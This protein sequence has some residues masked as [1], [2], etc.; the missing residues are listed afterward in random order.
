MSATVRRVQALLAGAATLLAV[1]PSV[2]R[3]E[4][5]HV[6]VV[7]SL[8]AELGCPVDWDAGCAA[9]RLGRIGPSTFAGRFTVPAG[10]FEYAIATGADWE[11]TAGAAGQPRPLV[12]SGPAEL[13]FRYDERAGAVTVTPHGLAG[14]R[15]TRADRALADSALGSPGADGA[16]AGATDVPAGQVY[17]VD[18]DRFANGDPSNDSAA[19]TG[20]V[21]DRSDP[22]AP[23]GG[24]L[25]GI[26]ERLDYIKGLGTTAIWLTSPFPANGDP[27]AGDPG[28]PAPADAGRAD[29]TRI[30]PRL[31]TA[32][33]LAE[34]VEQAHDRQMTVV[35]D[36]GPDPDGRQAAAARRAW[37]GVDGFGVAGVGA[38]PLGRLDRRFQEQAVA[39]AGGGETRG[40]A[41]AFADD[42]HL[43]DAEAASLLTLLGDEGTGRI[44]HLVPG[45]T[46]RERL[47]RVMFAHALMFTLRGQ[48]VIRYGD[49]QGLTGSGRGAGA[50]QDLFAT[51]V[52]EYASEMVLGG[53]EGSLDRYDPSAPLYRHIASLAALRR[54]HP[55]LADGAQVTRFASDRAGILAVSRIDRDAQAE[56]LV[57]AND[58]SVEASA[59]F[60]TA[61]AGGTFVS[62]HGGGSPVQ[63]DAQGTVWVSV[64]PL[65]VRVFRSDRP[66][67]PAADLRVTVVSPL[68]GSV[69]GGEVELRVA[70]TATD[71]VEVVLAQRVIGA[72]SWHVLGS[73]DAAP[74]RAFDDVSDVPAGTLVEYR[75]ILRDA[76][77]R[78][79]ARSWA[80]TVD[81][82]RIP[83][84]GPGLDDG[85]QPEAVSLVGALA[86]RLGCAAEDDPTCAAAQLALDVDRIWRA[87]FRLPGGSHTYGVAIVP[88]T[89]Q[90]PGAGVDPDGRSIDVPAGGADVTFLYDHRTGNV[91]SSLERIAV[92]V[93]SFQSEMGCAADWD[94]GCMRAWLQD[95]DE[96]G[97]LTLATSQVPVGRYEVAVAVASGLGA[98]RGST[99]AGEAGAGRGPVTAFSVVSAGSVTT[100]RWDATGAAPR[101]QVLPPAPTPDVTLPGARWLDARTLAYPAWRLPAGLDPAWLRFRLHRGD[102]LA[103]DAMSLGGSPVLLTPQPDG[104]EGNI[105]LRLPEWYDPADVGQRTQPEAV[106]VY[107]DADRLLDA[108]GVTRGALS[109]AAGSPGPP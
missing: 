3:G 23:H 65:S 64:P 26:I 9:T 8:Q 80:V 93:G 22:A 109:S 42:D 4:P 55:A 81:G 68:P 27:A 74:F 10:S 32:A 18:I 1:T 24:D 94:P 38:E 99:E 34:L 7:G 12:V 20:A 51:G 60:T 104:A 71:P 48:P 98:G 17:V 96:D 45:A 37:D 77:G 49:E 13:E 69:V 54:A 87:T 57:V 89:G 102:D 29:V 66:I 92:A 39:V 85:A 75:A 14:D 25:R 31:G 41:E 50:R 46:E 90:E 73:D 100:F 70:V 63:A 95:P 76:A 62:V 19:T 47:A 40:L 72:R 79:A 16:P 86:R 53:P 84:A 6:T 105:V 88:G 97:E 52:P 56:Y 108:T 61:T 5:A 103:V 82:T 106:G 36:V 43:S 44:G 59:S 11:R 107:D 101:V 30:D 83:R 35:V 21:L 15:A 91:A 78:L 2:A 58:S 28:D 33:D 67:A